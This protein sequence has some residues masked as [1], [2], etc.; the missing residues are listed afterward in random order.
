MTPRQKQLVRDSFAAVKD[1]AEP[2]AQLFYGRLFEFYPQVRPMFGNDMRLQGRKLMATIDAAI[3]SLDD[4]DRARPMLR[5]LGRRHAGYGVEPEH[6]D[7]VM[8]SLIWAIGQAI[9]LNAEQRQAWKEVIAA[10]NAEML[11]GAAEPVSG[12]SA[13]PAS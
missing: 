3:E 10:I 6:Y 8:A 11:A 7:L 2:L 1:M 12:S 9:G 13:R 5:D 4:F